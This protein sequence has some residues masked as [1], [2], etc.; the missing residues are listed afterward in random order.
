MATGLVCALPDPAGRS[1][2]LE[3]CRK[4][5]QSRSR[6][7]PQVA[8]SP[9]SPLKYP[10]AVRSTLRHLVDPAAIQDCRLAQGEDRDILCHAR[11][12]HESFSR[13]PAAGSSTDRCLIIGSSGAEVPYLAAHL[14]YTDITCLA[15]S[16]GDASEPVRAI[17]NHPQGDRPHEFT[18]IEHDPESRCWPL[19]DAQFSLAIF[20]GG[21]EHLH[22]DPEFAL[23]ELNRV[24]IPGAT[25]SV[26]AE[27]AI[28]FEA[29]HSILRGEPVSSRLNGANGDG[30]RRSYTPRQIGDLLE[31]T[32]WRVNELTTIVSDPPAHWSWWHRILFKRLAANLRRGAGLAEP[33]WNAFVLAQATKIGPPTRQYPRWLYQDERIRHLKIEMLEM[34]SDQSSNALSA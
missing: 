34:L 12:L 5:C 6:A 28:S 27:N 22:D 14:N 10:R 13:L 1:M 4:N 9:L 30:R 7:F 20:W 26:V 18:L 24:C 25:I 23:F 19:A 15:P 29:T 16:R 11:R 3:G 33:Y 2:F 21:L 32:G 8:M 17:R 31:G